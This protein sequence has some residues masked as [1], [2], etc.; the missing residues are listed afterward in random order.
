M[1]TVFTDMTYLIFQIHYMLNMKPISISILFL[2]CSV[3][4]RKMY[5]ICNMLQKVP[6]TWEQYSMVAHFADIIRCHII[7]IVISY[8]WFALFICRY[9]TKLF[10]VI[11]CYLWYITTD[12][13]QDNWVSTFS[14]GYQIICYWSILV[15]AFCT[16]AIKIDIIPIQFYQYVII[17]Y[18]EW[19]VLNKLL[20]W[21]VSILLENSI[22][23]VDSL[24]YKIIG[25]IE[26][27]YY[28]Y[29]HVLW[30][31]KIKQLTFKTLVLEFII[32]VSFKKYVPLKNILQL[33]IY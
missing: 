27:T 11:D 1:N 9:V 16:M 28:E 4:R 10:I 25:V 26:I 7:R 32:Y 30:V 29:F 14:N 31:L 2:K 33:L 5:L 15:S 23:M 21:L 17:F 8:G 13:W 6:P 22:C 24:C 3:E 20:K 12:L 18:L 19:I